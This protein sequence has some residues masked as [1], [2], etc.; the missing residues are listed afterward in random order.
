[1]KKTA[2]NRKFLILTGFLLSSF[3]GIVIVLSLEAAK[4]KIKADD[5]EK[6]LH[7]GAEFK[8]DALKV[9]QPVKRS[10]VWLKRIKEKRELSKTVEE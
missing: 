10:L 1:E 3:M 9:Y 8:T 4:A 5:Y 6:A 2:P 7:L